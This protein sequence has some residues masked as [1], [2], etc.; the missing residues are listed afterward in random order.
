MGPMHIYFMLIFQS[1]TCIYI[2]TI[3]DYD[4]RGCN[5]LW[6]RAGMCRQNGRFSSIGGGGGG[7]GHGMFPF[8]VQLPR[9]GSMS[10]PWNLWNWVWA[11][12][13]GNSIL[14]NEFQLETFCGT[15]LSFC[16]NSTPPYPQRYAAT[17]TWWQTITRRINPQ[18]PKDAIWRLRKSLEEATWRFLIYRKVPILSVRQ[19]LR[20]S[21]PSPAYIRRGGGGLIIR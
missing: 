21:R 15:L 9:Y 11:E 14:G 2:F 17:D 20:I 19:I 3:N 12:Y 13:G 6:W 4:S 8:L 18:K 7:G 16:N 1:D 10:I 5:T